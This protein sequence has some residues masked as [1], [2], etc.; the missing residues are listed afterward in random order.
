MGCANSKD[1]K[2]DP[3]MYYSPDGD[4]INFNPKFHHSASDELKYVSSHDIVVMSGGDECYV[5]STAWLQK[6]ISYAK[7]QLQGP[8]GPISNLLL[9][10][11]GDTFKVK[12]ALVVKKDFRPVCKNVWEYYFAAYGGGPVIMFHG[13]H[14]NGSGCSTT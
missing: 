11:P 9:V 14:C 2:R 3:Q 5:L 13:K 6:W 1:S 10:D 12:K 7:G 8:I 4:L